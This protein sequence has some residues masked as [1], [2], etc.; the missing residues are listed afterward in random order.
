MHAFTSRAGRPVLL[1]LT[2]V[3]LGCGSSETLAG[4]HV[5]LPGQWT[6]FTGR[7]LQVVGSYDDVSVLLPP[8]AAVA[9]RTNDVILPSGKRIHLSARYV[10]DNGTIFPVGRMGFGGQLGGLSYRFGRVGDS[11][12]RRYAAVELQSSDTL[13]VGRVVWLSGNPG[14]LP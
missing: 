8:E 3:C 2:A 7:D 10:G 4:P 6:R 13:V 12:D 5:L 14:P 1:T 9:G 11:V